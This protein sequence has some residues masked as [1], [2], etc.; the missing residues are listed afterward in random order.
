MKGQK[1]FAGHVLGGWQANT[2]LQIDGGFP[3]TRY[4]TIAPAGG[5]C[6]FNLDGVPNDRPNEPAF[7][8]HASNISNAAFEADN[9]NANLSSA[10]FL[11]PEQGSTV[12]P[13]PGC[14][15]AAVNTS[16]AIPTGYVPIDGNLGR[17]SFRGRTS[18]KLTFRS[19]RTSR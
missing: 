4:C 8:N 5:P 1:G 13:V 11:C 6:D 12:S 9:P 14:T 2:I 3:W 10:S 15:P 7:G 16:G 17:N 19:S 18:A